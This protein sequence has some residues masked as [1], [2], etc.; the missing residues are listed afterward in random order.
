MENFD[1]FPLGAFPSSGG[2]QLIYSGLGASYQHVDN[3]Q[4]VSPPQALH[5]VGSS[6]FSGTAYHPVALPSQLTFEGSVFVDQIV[7]C[8]CTP[9]L[10]TIS[11]YNPT[12]GTF[13]TSYGRV[14]FNCDGNIYGDVPEF[15]ELTS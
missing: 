14:S 5:L 4:F 9:L 2:W 11:L 12:L 3:T 13:G 15:V 10:A 1:N 8:G 6:C 7:G